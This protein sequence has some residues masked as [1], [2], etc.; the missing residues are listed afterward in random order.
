MRFSSE[1]EYELYKSANLEFARTYVPYGI[2]LEDFFKGKTNDG[3]ELYIREL[4]IDTIKGLELFGFRYKR[5]YI[6][7]KELVDSRLV[8]LKETKMG[9]KPR[10]I[11]E[12]LDNHELL[13]LC[14]MELAVWGYP[15][16]KKLS[17]KETE[18]RKYR[19]K[20]QAESDKIYNKQIDDLI[21]VFDT[22]TAWRESWL[23]SFSGSPTPVSSIITEVVFKF[24]D[25]EGKEP[26]TA[27]TKTSLKFTNK[28]AYMRNPIFEMISEYVEIMKKNGHSAR[29]E[30]L[31]RKTSK[32]NKPI[33]NYYFLRKF[34]DYLN[35][36]TELKASKRIQQIDQ[37]WM[38]LRIMEVTGKYFTMKDGPHKFDYLEKGD[39]NR[40]RQ[41]YYD[42]RVLLITL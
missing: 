40:L 33:R 5:F 14:L 32:E 42:E 28:P 8:K 2:T 3:K 30:W 9:E 36:Y 23:S 37:L 22:V 31:K 39:F 11:S 26:G 18:E 38:Y 24:I 41:W 27:S 6:S 16:K 21:T 15:G 1:E 7:T 19:E 20:V 17:E 35:T 34:I 4:D 10:F 29:E 12:L 13:I 25:F